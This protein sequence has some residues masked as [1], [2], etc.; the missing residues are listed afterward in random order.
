MLR[1]LAL[2]R[3][4]NGM[5]HRRCCLASCRSDPIGDETFQEVLGKVARCE[6]DLACKFLILPIDVVTVEAL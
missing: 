5:E 1:E 3:L 4:L 2:S 6:L